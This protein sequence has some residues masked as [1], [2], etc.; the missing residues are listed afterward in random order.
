MAPSGVVTARE[1]GSSPRR[2]H[3]SLSTDSGT[4]SP[5]RLCGEERREGEDFLTRRGALDCGNDGIRADGR[6]ENDPRHGARLRRARD[7]PQGRGARQERPLAERDPRQDGGARA[8]GRRH[9]AGAR[10]R[11]HGHAQLR[12]RDGG[13]QRRLRELRRHHEREQLA[14]L[15]P[16]LQ[17]RHRRAEEARARTRRERTKA[18]VLRAHRADERLRRADDGHQRREDARAAGSSTARR[19]GS[20]TAPTPTGSSSSP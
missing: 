9:P 2:R 10:R 17:V 19:T 20:P 5:Q 4:S 18:R 14:L 15:R 3:R 13:D 16:G 11:R 6:A 8:D 1:C 7:R 12:A